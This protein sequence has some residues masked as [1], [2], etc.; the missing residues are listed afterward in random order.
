MDITLS[1][2]PRIHRIAVSVL[3]FISGITVATWASRIP[4]IK[5]N[6]QLSEAALGAVLFAL[7][8]GELISLPISGWLISK[9][10]SRQLVIAAAIFFPL[11]LIL[12]SVAATVWQ[13]VIV[14]FLFGVWGNLINI[15]M[16]TQAV[17]VENLYGRSI[18]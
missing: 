1:I 10:G 11:T 9:F 15:A 16:N 13:L 17:R 12:L 8:V 2:N 5:N 3:F 18:M 14:L 6:L 7:P 4:D